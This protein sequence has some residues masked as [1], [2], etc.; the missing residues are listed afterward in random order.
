MTEILQSRKIL[1]IAALVLLVVCLALYLPLSSPQPFAY[2]ES[3]YMWAG[4]QGFI[5]NAIDRDAIPFTEYIRRGLELARDPSKRPEFSRFIRESGDLGMYRHY[6]GPVFYYW[7]ALLDMVGVEQEDTYRGGGL[8]LHAATALV[9]LFA[10]WQC[11]PALPPLAGFAAFLLYLFNRTALVAAT[12]LTQHS[13]FTFWAAV[14]LF[15]LSRYAATRAPRW[16][17][18]AAAALAVALAAVETAAVL[19]IAHVL[20]VLYVNWPLKTHWRTVLGL[21]L[22]SAGA[23]V[24]ALALVWPAGVVLLSVLKGFMMLVYIAVFRKTFS[25]IGPLELL[26]MKVETS[27]WELIFLILVALSCFVVWRKARHRTELVPWLGFTATFFLVL[28]KITAPYN[29]YYAPLTMACCVIAAYALAEFSM[30]GGRMVGLVL[31]LATVVSVTGSAWQ[32]REVMIDIS[33]QPNW[34]RPLITD[35]RS[36][37]LPEGRLHVPYQAVPSLHYYFPQLKTQGFDLDWTADALAKSLRQPG[38]G[39]V[40]ICEWEQCELVGGM[41]QSRR[42]L[43]PVGP[44]GKPVFVAEVKPE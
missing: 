2:D 6:H 18:G 4:R 13:M 20:T 10:F 24:L 42:L 16:L 1:T 35:L 23:F 32:Q 26:K 22:R 31:A 19:G 34:L 12:T 3:D 11:F 5:A 25:P 14:M 33:S 17:Y 40:L 28:L 39:R 8:Y 36:R 37:P 41:L 30:R 44:N 7:I 43:D 38:A 21:M 29:Y 9:I 27:P 15:L